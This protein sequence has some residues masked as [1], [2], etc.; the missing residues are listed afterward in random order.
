[1]SSLMIVHLKAENDETN[2]A[3][4]LDHIFK[5]FNDNNI[6]I[7]NSKSNRL[8]IIKSNHIINYACL[9]N[10]PTTDHLK[11]LGIY[12]SN[13]LNFSHHINYV[14]KNASKNVYIIRY[15]TL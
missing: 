5:W 9:N 3:S 2:C 4:E 10:I 6:L 15:Y 8:P 12:V 1:M 11:I 13:N 7:N 14:I